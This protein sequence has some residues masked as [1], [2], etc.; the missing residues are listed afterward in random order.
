MEKTER[1]G[2]ENGRTDRGE[3][4]RGASSGQDRDLTSVMHQKSMAVT[5]AVTH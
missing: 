4:V 2:K 5:L 3:E 1:Q